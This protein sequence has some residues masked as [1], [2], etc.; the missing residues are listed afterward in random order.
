[1]D[2][3]KVEWAGILCSLLG[4]YFSAKQARIA[5][6]WNILASALYGYIFY[7]LGLFSDMELQGFFI[8]MAL[9]GFFQW[10]RSNVDWTPEKSGRKELLL[11]IFLSLFFGAISGY[12]HI[13]FVPNVSFPYLD[14][15]L[16]G[17]SI[18]GTYLA[19]KRKIENWFVWIIVDMVY[20]GMYLQKG[21]PGTAALY[22]L[23]ILMAFYGYVSWQKKMS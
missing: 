14:A 12:L 17:L 19:A 2:A 16:S 3:N 6:I 9:F 15:C 5:W 22:G 10:S 23:F 4:V 8:L 11:G 1:M 21:I 18:W 20:I 7:G 13:R